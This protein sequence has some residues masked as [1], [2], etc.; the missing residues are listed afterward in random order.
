MNDP[1]SGLPVIN[2]AGSAQDLGREID[3]A[4][5]ELGFFYVTG[6]GVDPALVTAL[7]R[8]ARAFFA[9]PVA[10]KLRIA[11]CH[12]GR[13]WRGYFPVGGEL[14]SGRPDRKEGLYFGTE[15]PPEDPRVLAGLPLHGPNLFPALPG[16]RERVLT[17]MEAV[18]AAGQRVL[19]GIAAGLALPPGYFR[20]HYTRDPTVLFRIFNYPPA[21]AEEQMGVG[22]H[23][24]YGFITLLWQD[25][26][27]GLELYHRN[28]WMAVPPLPGSFVINVGDMLERLTAGRYV[29]ALHRARN[30]TREDR[31]SMPLFLDPGFDALLEPLQLP[32]DSAPTPNVVRARDRWDGLDLTCIHGTYGDYLVSKVAKVFPALRKAH[33]R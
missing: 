2:L 1:Q 4:C 24:D 29:S 25:A 19:D 22:E 5:R 30:A 7:E 12:G 18:T 28:R 23:T 26:S 32:E 20:R 27:G 9:L 17:Y 16:L 6:H 13:A 3:R 31:L 33:L 14:T 11:M 15:L 8:D 21:G 10:E